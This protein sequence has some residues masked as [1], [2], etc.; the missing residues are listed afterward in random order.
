MGYLTDVP[1]A[2]DVVGPF[3]FLYLVF[4]ALGFLVSCFYYYRPW[5]PPAGRLFRRK[6]VR[7][8]TTIAM[9]IFGA[10]LF[11]LGIRLLQVNPFGFGMRLWMYLC[12]LAAAIMLLIFAWEARKALR[13]PRP[14]YGAVRDRASAYYR[15]PP[16]RP[17]K[18]RRV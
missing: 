14:E 15:Q 16:R 18:R 2:N 6:S 4:F 3:S 7:K 5:Q 9:W 11:F 13:K 12:F 10:G 17:V 8:A 1:G